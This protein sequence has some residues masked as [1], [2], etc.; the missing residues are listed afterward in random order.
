HPHGDARERF[1]AR[2]EVGRCLGVSESKPALVYQPPVTQDKESAI[3]CFGS[4][5]LKCCVESF[6]VDRSNPGLVTLAARP[7]PTAVAIV[8]GHIHINRAPL[9]YPSAQ[10]AACRLLVSSFTRS[11]N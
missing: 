7:A 1:T 6:F 11:K 3:F 2:G 9:A 4:H 5:Q 8:W 10:P